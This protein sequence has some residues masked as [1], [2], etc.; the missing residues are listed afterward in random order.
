VRLGDGKRNSRVQLGQ[1]NMEG[2]IYF[3]QI[4][5]SG[6]ILGLAWLVT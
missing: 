2:D 4:G 1:Y 3:F 6:V 5:G